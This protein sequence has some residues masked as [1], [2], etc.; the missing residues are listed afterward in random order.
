MAGDEKHLS[1]LI[2]CVKERIFNYA[3]TYYELYKLAK[4]SFE[5]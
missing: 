5:S 4:E 3:L 1:L 2:D